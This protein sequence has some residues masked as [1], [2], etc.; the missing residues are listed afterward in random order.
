MAVCDDWP[1]LGGI[2]HGSGSFT[3]PTAKK[4]RVRKVNSANRFAAFL[5]RPIVRVARSLLIGLLCLLWTNHDDD[6]KYQND[7]DD[8]GEANTMPCKQR[9]FRGRFAQFSRLSKKG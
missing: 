3:E 4:K 9:A 1:A 8:E 7:D 5:P 6:D 2:R